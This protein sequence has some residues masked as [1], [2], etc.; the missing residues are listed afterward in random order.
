MKVRRTVAAAALIGMAALIGCRE[1][2]TVWVKPGASNEEFS[3]GISIC[4]EQAKVV[5]HE[6]DSGQVTRTDQDKYRRC[7]T[8]FGF[9]PER[10]GN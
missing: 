8:Q 6:S 7:L 9:Q 5:V 3:Q 4:T 10:R 1:E 2:N